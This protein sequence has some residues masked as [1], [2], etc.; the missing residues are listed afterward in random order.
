MWLTAGRGEQAHINRGGRIVPR[1]R[2]KELRWHCPDFSRVAGRFWS[3]SVTDAELTWKLQMA[4]DGSSGEAVEI[5]RGDHKRG[6]RGSDRGVLCPPHISVI[7]S[8]D[9]SLS[10]R[11]GA[12]T[13]GSYYSPSEIWRPGLD[14]PCP[15]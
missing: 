6:H 9:G 5:G 15:L 10:M 3:E 13:T 1:S 14:G 12:R 2:G 8:P 7:D 4:Q 11:G